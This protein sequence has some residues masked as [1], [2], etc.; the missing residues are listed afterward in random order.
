MGKTTELI[1][2][3]KAYKFLIEN[4]LLYKYQSG[5]IPGHSTMFQLVDIYH[6][7]CQ[8]FDQNQLSCMT[9]FDISKAFDQVLHP[10]LLHKLKQNG[11]SGELLLCFF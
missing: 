10:G 8:T 7:I 5:F 1:V 3:K 9:F 2:F 4:D 6:R 11:V